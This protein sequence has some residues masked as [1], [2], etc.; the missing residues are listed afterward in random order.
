MSGSF[1]VTPRAASDL[2]EIA[3][4]TLRT[5]GREQRD[6][7]LRDLDKRF[8]WLAANPMLGKPRGDI[9]EGYRSYAQ[10]SHVIYYLVR[11]TCIDII[12]VLHHR[13]DEL[14]YFDE[15]D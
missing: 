8:S 12:G 7:Y 13:M 9:K 5:W 10:G 11:E 4:Y 6:A 1:R 3:R 2:R 15:S 14:G